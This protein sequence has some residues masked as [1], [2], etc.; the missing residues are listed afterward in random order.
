MEDIND[1]LGVPT[2]M[3]G[4]YHHAAFKRLKGGRHFPDGVAFILLL[5]NLRGAASGLSAALRV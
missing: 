5:L 4:P 3:I 2:N 1:G